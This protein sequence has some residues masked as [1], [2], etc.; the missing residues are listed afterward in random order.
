MNLST[1]LYKNYNCSHYY[2]RIRRVERYQWSSHNPQHEPLKILGELA[3]SGRISCFA[4]LVAHVML[5]YN[6]YRQWWAG[7]CCFTPGKHLL[8][9]SWREQATIRLDDKKIIIII[10]FIKVHKRHTCNLTQYIT[11]S[12]LINSSIS[13][14]DNDKILR[15]AN[16][17]CLA[18]K[19]NPQKLKIKFISRGV[20]S[21]IT[22][23]WSMIEKY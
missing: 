1:K 14:T 17:N 11:Y 13:E 5:L 3:Y 23:D 15:Q 2:Q 22:L 18:P 19:D 16:R 7:D 9:K 10:I 4:P 20:L 6:M 8:D 21:L 12:I